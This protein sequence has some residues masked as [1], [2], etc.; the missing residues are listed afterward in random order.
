DECD[1]VLCTVYTGKGVSST[2]VAS[3][4]AQRIRRT[5]LTARELEVLNL[6]AAGKSNLEIG[7]QLFI[8]EGTVKAHVNNIL[9]KLCVNDRT[10]AVI[11]AIQRGIVHLD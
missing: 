8:S 6:I 5:E 4:L 11:T 3:K 10:Q 1:D 2:E 7:N 9:T